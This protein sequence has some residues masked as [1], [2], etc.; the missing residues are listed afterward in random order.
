MYGRSRNATGSVS[1]RSSAC[2]THTPLAVVVNAMGCAKGFSDDGVH[3][4]R[5]RGVLAQEVAQR[6]VGGVAVHPDDLLAFVDA[7]VDVGHHVVERVGVL[8]LE[9]VGQPRDDL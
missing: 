9:A 1:T 6:G 7:L 3:A 5:A 4:R 8:A 2:S